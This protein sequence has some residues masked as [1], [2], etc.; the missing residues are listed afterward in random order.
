MEEEM[1]ETYA[2]EVQAEIDKQLIEA[3]VAEVKAGGL[4]WGEGKVADAALLSEGNVLGS[5]QMTSDPGSRDKVTLYS[6]ET[7]MPSRVLVN[8]LGKK[9]QAKLPD[10]RKAWSPTPT[11][12]YSMGSTKCLLHAEHPR[13]A[14]FDEIG[15]AGKTCLKSN[16][17]SEF[18][19]RQHMLH[20][21][22]QEWQV[23]EEAR[24]RAEK[25]EERDFRRM[26]MAQWESMNAPKSRRKPDGTEE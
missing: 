1:V 20:R 17:P 14:E 2:P 7:G 26:Q 5:M 19:V 13:R 16:I 6:T 8:M 12:D 11:K 24:E 4:A 3:Q 10:G 21:H 22:K 18:E 25:Q 15:L 23:M 9:L